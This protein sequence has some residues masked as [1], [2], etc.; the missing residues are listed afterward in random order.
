MKQLIIRFLLALGL[1]SSSFSVSAN[2]QEASLQVEQT[3]QD[4]IAVIDRHSGKETVDIDE[5]SSEIEMIVNRDVDFQYI[6]NWVMGKYYRQATAAQRSQFA[7]VFK[8]TLIRTYAK[9]LLE[10]D[11]EKYDIAAPT[12]ESPEEDKQIVSV[13]VTSK[14]GT[15]YTIVNYMVKKKGKWK[16]VNVMINGINLRITF[17]NQFA[18]M[19]QRTKY[20]IG[21]VIGNWKA[22][23][24]EK[25]VQE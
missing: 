23:I 19:M 11:I 12:A 4:M 20:D 13:N 18:D 8:Q 5:V 22:Q 25:P 21:A 2:W 9:S 6:A 15:S 16:L 24:D 7:Q 17:K 14:A 10:F 1:M 3:I